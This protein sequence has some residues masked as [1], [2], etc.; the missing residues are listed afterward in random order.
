MNE[1]IPALYTLSVILGIILLAIAICFCEYKTSESEWNDG[2][3]ECGG[4]WM[5]VEAVGHRYSTEYIY[6][7][8]GC[9]RMIKTAFLMED[10]I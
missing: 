7:C 2:H 5:Y 9:G 10:N 6:K 4:S 3:C 1:N 8:D